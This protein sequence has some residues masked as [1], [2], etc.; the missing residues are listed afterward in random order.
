[1]KPPLLLII[2][3]LLL[4]NVYS[5][6]SQLMKHNAPVYRIRITTM[7]DNVLK[8][9]LTEVKDS[10]L[11]IYPG[12][13]KEWKHGV[14]YPP[15]EFSYSNI[16]QA[17]VKRKNGAWRGMLIGGSIGTVIFATSFI[18]PNWMEKNHPAVFAFFAIPVGL[19]TGAIAGGTHHKH[20]AID[21][22][23]QSFQKFQK[24]M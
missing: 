22:N 7:Q 6:E 4:A 23:A 16:K 15:V 5:Q 19:I 14:K 20:H 11:V 21:G 18:V 10:S 24:E 9:L 13:R 3:C 12:K 1:M 2:S 8:G 17:S